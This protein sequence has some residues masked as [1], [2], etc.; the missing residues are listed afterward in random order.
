MSYTIDLPGG[1]SE[2]VTVTHRG[3]VSKDDML[4]CRRAAFS[5]LSAMESSRMLVDFS[6][7]AEVPDH[8]FF[9]MFIAMNATRLREVGAIA[10]LRPVHDHAH[11]RLLEETAHSYRI[12]CRTFDDIDIA[13]G[14]LLSPPSGE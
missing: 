6:A 12:N 14:W 10:V 4:A 5:A 3:A 8:D 2:F 1:G 11:L 9:F 7:A 13:T